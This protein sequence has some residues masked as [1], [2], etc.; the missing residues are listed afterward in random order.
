MA[1]YP[2]SSL[3]LAFSLLT[4]GCSTSQD[5]SGLKQACTTDWYS[6][7]EKQVPTDDG[8]GHG[9]DLGSGEWRSVVEFKLGIHGNPEVPS[10]GTDQWCDYID[11]YYIQ[12]VR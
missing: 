1:T 5:I 8:H 10:R 11:K 6:V 3:L 2:V 4:L 7:V 12:P 9:P